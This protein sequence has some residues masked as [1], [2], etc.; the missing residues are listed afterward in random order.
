MMDRPTAILLFAREEQW[1][2][3]NKNW[4]GHH[5]PTSQLFRSWNKLAASKARQ[6]GLPFFRSTELIRHQGSFG[7]QLSQALRALFDKGFEQ[8]ICIGNDTPGLSPEDLLEASNALAQGR[9]PLGPD[10]RGGIYLF[11]CRRQDLSLLEQADLPWQSTELYEAFVK[12][13][14]PSIAVQE[15]RRLADT[16]SRTDILRAL[17]KRGI[18]WKLAF[19]W[20]R[21]LIAAPVQPEVLPTLDRGSFIAL[22]ASLRGPPAL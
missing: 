5:R 19:N 17:A 16:H 18:D 1:E 4:R 11:G 7:H 2:S 14:H 22:T 13:F 3:R 15:L 10:Q 12:A 9:L 8:V 20:L 21:L 6:A